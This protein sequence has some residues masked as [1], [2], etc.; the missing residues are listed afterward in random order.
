[1]AM[2]LTFKGEPWVHS[3]FP[4]Y[5]W[6]CHS[7]IRRPEQLSK[8]LHLHKNYCWLMEGQLQ[9]LWPALNPGCQLHILINAFG[10]LEEKRQL[11]K[12]TQVTFELIFLLPISWTFQTRI[13]NI[14]STNIYWISFFF[15][16]PISKFDVGSRTRKKTIMVLAHK[17]L[18][19]FLWG[20]EGACSAFKWIRSCCDYGGLHYPSQSFALPSSH[21]VRHVTP[22]GSSP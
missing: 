21:A 12:Y 16:L 3:I 20:E 7:Q 22:G 8:G 9:N 14:H 17:E 13:L 19:V 1:M 15:F 5:W 2:L 18:I 4:H 10:A 6:A 11:H